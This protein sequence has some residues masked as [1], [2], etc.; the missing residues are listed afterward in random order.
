MFYTKGCCIKIAPVDRRQV[1]LGDL[2]CTKLYYTD[3]A[4]ILILIRIRILLRMLHC[5]SYTMLCDP[6]HIVLRPHS[7]ASRRA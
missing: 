1:A 6:N 3:T 4:T 7:L 5:T 2:Y